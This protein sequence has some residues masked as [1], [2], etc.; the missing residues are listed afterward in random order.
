MIRNAVFPESTS[1]LEFG[2]GTGRLARRLLRDHLP[3]DA[4]YTG[5]DVSPV[6]VRIAR[7]R[8]KAYSTRATVVLSDGSMRLPDHPSGFDR[9][10]STYVMDL[11]SPEDIADLLTE[12]RAVLATEGLL[13]LVSLT[14]G[15]G[16]LSRSLGWIWNRIHRMEPRLLGGCRPVRL[17]EFL[18]PEA[19]TPH[20]HATITTWGVASEILIAEV[21]D[22]DRQSS[23]VH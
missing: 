15:K 21:A 14:C 12:A 20:H 6:M 13:C 7:N 23:D 4:T 8:L 2:C 10:V 3:P 19:W 17:V 16:R 5:I 11:L 18:D 9:V 1:I 22:R